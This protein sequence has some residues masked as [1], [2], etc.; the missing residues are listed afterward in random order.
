MLKLYLASIFFLLKILI[1]DSVL[2]VDSVF[3]VLRH[4][5]RNPLYVY[6]YDKYNREYWKQRGGLGNL[7]EKGENRIRVA[8]KN[9][10]QQYEMLLNETDGSSDQVITSTIER[11]KKTADIFMEVINKKAKFERNDKMLNTDAECKKSKKIRENLL[12]QNATGLMPNNTFI[13]NLRNKTGEKYNG[14]TLENLLLLMGLADTLKIERDQMKL[15]VSEWITDKETANILS[16]LEKKSFSTMM[17]DHEI[18]RL[19]AGLL[20]KN[21]RDQ[22]EKKSSQRFFLYSTHDYNQIVLLQAL[23]LYDQLDQN[24]KVPPTYV[25]GV[26]F[27][28]YRNE[29]GEQQ[30][31]WI[32]F[33]YRQFLDNENGTITKVDTQMVPELCQT[34]LQ[35][36]DGTA[37]NTQKFCSWEQFSGELVKNLIPENWDKECMNSAAIKPMV[38]FMVF[39]ITILT[40]YFSIH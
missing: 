5:D 13:D 19:R 34:E 28:V 15:N 30:S 32:R 23:N 29:S 36:H 3:V 33:I 40:S 12:I 11:A 10:R 25:S 22:I 38:T 39:I 37:I 26:V 1:V 21:I 9:Y 14:D 18:Q 8:A 4:G 27:E 20:L 6:P 7:I 17:N 35:F 2:V 24:N 31:K 16:E